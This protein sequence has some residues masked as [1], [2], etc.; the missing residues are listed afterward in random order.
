MYYAKDLY[1]KLDDIREAI[2]DNSEPDG[3]CRFSI[4]EVVVSLNLA[5]RCITEPEE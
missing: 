2:E 5:L 4:N 3:T 1:R